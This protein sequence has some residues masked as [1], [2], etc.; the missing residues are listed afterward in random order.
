MQNKL[1]QPASCIFHTNPTYPTPAGSLL[2]KYLQGSSIDW[3]DMQMA[4]IL[5]VRANKRFSLHFLVREYLNSLEGI[6][7]NDM[8]H[9]VEWMLG[10]MVGERL[11]EL[12]PRIDQDFGITEA[13]EIFA[14]EKSNFHEMLKLVSMHPVL[15][16]HPDFL[17][18]IHELACSLWSIGQ[19]KEAAEMFE[20]VLHLKSDVLGLE[21]EGTLYTFGSFASCLDSLGRHEEAVA[22]E[23]K[24]VLLRKNVLGPEHSDALVSKTNLASSLGSLGEHSEAVQ[25]GYEVLELRM[26]DDILS[27]PERLRIM[28]NLA[29]SLWSLG[30]S[31]W[32][33]GI[34]REVLELRTSFLGPKHPDTLN[35]MSNL[36]DSLWE[37]KECDAALAMEREACVLHK[38][39]FGVDHPIT[40]RAMGN[41][42]SSLGALGLHDEAILLGGQVLEFR[43][44]RKLPSVL[45]TLDNL[46][47]SMGLKGQLVEAVELQREALG[48]RMNQLGLE[49]SSTLR[50]KVGLASNLWRLG[51][52]SE[53]IELV[54][55]VALVRTRLLGKDDPSTI[56]VQATLDGL[57]RSS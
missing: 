18:E 54:R 56:S 20:G 27:W 53:A 21:D 22:I 39:V 50:T 34:E 25:L 41:L 4:A 55:D 19:Y 7:E 44:K 48:M 28:A 12:D 31:A 2:V 51:H 5:Q 40:M 42:A 10:P 47:F 8:I 1:S 14:N 52:K 29:A 24:V 17:G 45:T 35:A 16:R 33:I 38:E 32:A 49:H 6:L 57:L 3:A 26:K 36:A 9:F 46:S 43:R 11:N 13:F 37:I 30:E 15:Y 23:R